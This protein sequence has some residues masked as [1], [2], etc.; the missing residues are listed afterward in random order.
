MSNKAIKDS[1]SEAACQYPDCGKFLHYSRGLC[2]NCYMKAYRLGT[3]NDYR[4]RE[5]KQETLCIIKDCT[6]ISGYSNGMCKVHY[7]REKHGRDM[8]A[9]IQKRKKGRVCTHETCELPTDA[10]GYCRLHYQRMRTGVPLDG[11][12]DFAD[13]SDPWTWNKVKNTNGYV[14][15]RLRRGGVKYSILEHRLVMQEH[16]GH[17]LLPHE[18]VHHKNGVRDDNRLENLELWLIP[19][20]AGQRVDDLLDWVTAHY[21]AE[22]LDRLAKPETN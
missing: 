22:L 21:P 15:Y 4:L 16:M 2:Y 7:M 18:N 1:V 9:P 20:P 3:L 12:V 10:K 8:N 14:D 11:K 17:E 5:K 19:Q 6:D 13:P